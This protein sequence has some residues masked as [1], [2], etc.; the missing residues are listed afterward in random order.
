MNR[1]IFAL[2]VIAVF[3]GCDREPAQE[4]LEPEEALSSDGGA[5]VAPSKDLEEEASDPY[6]GMTFQ[7]TPHDEEHTKAVVS[8]HGGADGLTLYRG[9][10]NRA[11]AG[12]VDADPGVTLDV[13]RTLVIVKQSQPIVLEDVFETEMSPYDPNSDEYGEPQKFEIAAGETIYM[14]KYQGEG[15]CFAGYKGDV[16]SLSCPPL[17]PRFGA[18]WTGQ[19]D[20]VDFDWW[21]LV[22]HGGARGWVEVD[23]EDVKY[24]MEE[25]SP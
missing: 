1:W 9:A 8:Y 23:N 14:L 3:V 7:G 4:T 18:T 17:D 24:T 10:G 6:A 21:V 13:K 19:P 25:V 22:A 2:L 20:L 12:K 11:A 16:Y 15:M 5:D